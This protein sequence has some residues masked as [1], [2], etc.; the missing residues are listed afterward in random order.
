MTTDPSSQRHI[1]L[2]PN[3]VAIGIPIDDNFLIAA[4]KLACAAGSHELIIRYLCKSILEIELEEA[5]W[6]TKRNYVE[7]V[8]KICRKSFV[9]KVQDQSA[10]AK[11]DAL[12][13]RSRELTEERNSVLHRGWGINHQGIAVAKDENQQFSAPPSIAE[14]EATTTK[15]LALNVEINTARLNGF[16]SHA[17]TAAKINS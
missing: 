17:L 1:V 13:N 14:L 15:L 6:A 4:G 5:L 10:I 2:S 3:Q 9:N 12:L 11:L 7:D 16:I 8:R